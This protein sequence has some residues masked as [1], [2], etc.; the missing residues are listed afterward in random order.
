[1]LPP[2]EDA[3][4]FD[5]AED[6]EDEDETGLVGTG[7]PVELEDELKGELE[8]G[9]GETVPVEDE[10]AEMDEAE[11][12]AE[13]ESELEEDAEDQSVM[14]EEEDNAA[15]VDEEEDELDANVKTS[16]SERTSRQQSSTTGD[17]RDMAV[18]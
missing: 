13:D 6:D 1:M 17:G 11:E 4:E 12:A 7:L 5:G 14:E 3:E 16:S 15:V 8:G 10:T 9:T 18:Q 2:L